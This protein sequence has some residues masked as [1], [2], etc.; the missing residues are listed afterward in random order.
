MAFIEP[1]AVSLPLLQKGSVMRVVRCIVLVCAVLLSGSLA[2]ADRTVIDRSLQE[3]WT[4]FKE[5]DSQINVYDHLDRRLILVHTDEQNRSTILQWD[6]TT[7]GLTLFLYNVEITDLVTGQDQWGRPTFEGSFDSN[8]VPQVTGFVDV[9]P[10]G[11]LIVQIDQHCAVPTAR[12]ST[13]GDGSVSIGALREC[14]CVGN[15]GPICCAADCD[16]G[17]SC[18][19]QGDPNVKCEWVG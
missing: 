6:A 2:M 15:A 8:N 12:Y 17:N 5:G 13:N 1:W 10:D 4:Q 3:F 18:P 14:K 16:L 19:G 7:A 11:E 9:A